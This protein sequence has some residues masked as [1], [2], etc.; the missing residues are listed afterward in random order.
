MIKMFKEMT[1]K[2]ITFFIGSILFMIVQVWLELKI[3]GYMSD[4]TKLVTTGGETIDTSAWDTIYNAGTDEDVSE[5][6]D[7]AV[8]EE[9]VNIK[10]AVHSGTVT[11]VVKRPQESVIEYVSCGWSVIASRTK[12]SASL[13][14]FSSSPSPATFAILKCPCP[15]TG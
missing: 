13:K 8:E 11:P 10:T 1:K 6:I 3:P 4:I 9:P 2:E 7:A 12:S 14:F 5:Y 15:N